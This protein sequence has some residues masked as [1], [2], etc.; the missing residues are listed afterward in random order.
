M[1]EI[2]LGQLFGTIGF[3][4]DAAQRTLRLGLDLVVD[5]PRPFSRHLARRPPPALQ[6]G[7]RAMASDTTK[8]RLG[9]LGLKDL[10]GAVNHFCNGVLFG[11]ADV[12]EFE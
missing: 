1:V 9:D 3:R 2:E 7:F 5:P 11:P 12:V 4:G 8:L 6:C 10:V